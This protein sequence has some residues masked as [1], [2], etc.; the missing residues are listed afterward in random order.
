MKRKYLLISFSLAFI[1]MGCNI[2]YTYFVNLN[3]KSFAATEPNNIELYFEPN[4]PDKPFEVIGYV[5]IVIRNLF[6]DQTIALIEMKEQAAKRGAN[7]LLNIR[8]TG[9]R[10]PNLVGLAVKWK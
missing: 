7:A 3:N 5:N 9:G 2:G 4:K 10:D 8:M 1:F 6:K